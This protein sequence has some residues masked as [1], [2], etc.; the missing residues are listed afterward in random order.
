MPELH[1]GSFTVSVAC[2][3]IEPSTFPPGVP[4]KPENAGSIAMIGRSDRPNPR[5]IG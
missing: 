3:P 1:D 5:E 2:G 4:A